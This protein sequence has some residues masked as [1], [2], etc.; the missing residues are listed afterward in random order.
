MA[1]N[2]LWL[3]F[4]L[5]NIFMAVAADIWFDLLSIASLS[6][7]KMQR[8]SRQRIARM[9]PSHGSTK[10]QPEKVQLLAGSNYHTLR[11]RYFGEH[12]SQRRAHEH[13]QLLTHAEEQVLVD[14]MEHRSST[15]R[16]L[17]IGRYLKYKLEKVIGFRPGKR[18][19]SFNSASLLPRCDIL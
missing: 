12:T 5:S 6:L 2:I 4:F 11:R 19:L 10:T 16:P 15:G 14:W 9:K 7:K 8:H 1:D 18:W 17:S 3:P 13:Q